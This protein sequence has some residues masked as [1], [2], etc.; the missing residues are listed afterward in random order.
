MKLKIPIS[1]SLAAAVVLF[2]A[3]QPVA[4]ADDETRALIGGLIGGIIL[5]SAIDDGQHHVEV[6]YGHRRHH[7]HYDGCGCGGHYEWITV[8]VWVPGGWSFRYD[9]CGNRY[10]VRTHGHYIHKKKRVWV[11]HGHR[12]HGRYDHGYRDYGRRHY[13]RRDYDRGDTRERSKSRHR[14]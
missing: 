2:A 1:L 3:H 13:G 5:G 9:D 11:S 12:D 10:R 6:G 14:Y 7:R 8:R 4:H